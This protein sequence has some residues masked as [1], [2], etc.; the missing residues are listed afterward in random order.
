MKRFILLVLVIGLCSTFL[1]AAPPVYAK[2]G[3]KI[4]TMD[5]QSVGKRRNIL[6][7]SSIEIKAV[8]TDTRGNKEYYTGETGVKL[9]INLDLK[10]SQRISYLVFSAAGDYKTGS[11]ALQ[12]KYF[13]SK[14]AAGAGVGAGVAIL[15]GGFDKSF[16]LQPLAVE[17]MRGW[18][19]GGGL[20]YLYLQKDPTR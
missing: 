20:G 6:I 5:I 11:H 2:E 3:I 7:Q 8:F 12:G 9:G 14:I 18:G 19:I 4:G 10:E 16:S 1:F 13:G 17:T 15:I